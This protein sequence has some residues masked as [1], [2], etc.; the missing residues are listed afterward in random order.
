MTQEE[1]KRFRGLAYA[2]SGEL[3]IY[4]VLNNFENNTTN[5]SIAIFEAG[6]K[7]RAEKKG[8]LS[9]DQDE[10]VQKLYIVF[11]NASEPELL[12]DG[13]PV[14][15]LTFLTT[16]LGFLKRLHGEAW[17]ADFERTHPIKLVRE[18]LE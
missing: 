4:L 5:G 9:D 18:V 6:Q 7:F 11:G 14:F 8:L 2:A 1:C 12:T 13:V 16:C 3:L 10:I 15:Q 17:V